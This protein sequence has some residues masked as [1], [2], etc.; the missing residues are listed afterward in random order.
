MLAHN[1]TQ[2]LLSHFLLTVSSGSAGQ[3]P[4]TNSYERV[5]AVLLSYLGVSKGTAP[6][7]RGLQGAEWLRV[8]GVGHLHWAFNRPY[9]HDCTVVLCP[10][11]CALHHGVGGSGGIGEIGQF[12]DPADLC[13]ISTQKPQSHERSVQMFAAR[14]TVLAGIFCINI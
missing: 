13:E 10:V 9:V 4:L 3:C 8:W 11:S 7:L 6:H 12:H 1:E 2:V 14:G 5:T